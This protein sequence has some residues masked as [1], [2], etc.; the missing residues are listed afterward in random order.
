MNCPPGQTYSSLLKRCVLKE[1]VGAKG[2][3]AVPCPEGQIWNPAPASRRCVSRKVFGDLY[4]EGRLKAASAEQRRL[5]GTQ[6]ASSVK[7]PAKPAKVVSPVVPRAAA[8][9]PANKRNAAFNVG[10]PR[11]NSTMPPGLLREK[12]LEWV[13]KNCTNQEDPIMLEPYEEAELKDLRSMV[14]LNSGFCY[15]AETIDQHIKS[16]IERGVPIRD[17]LN[18]SY[19]LDSKDFGAIDTAG[20]RAKKSYKLPVEPVEIPANHYKLLIDVMDDPKFKYVFLYDDRKVKKLPGGGADYS[21]AIPDGA[22][23]GYIP[24]A[25]T[26]ELVTLIRKAYTKGRLFTRAT[27]PFL[28]C[29]FHLKKSKEFWA[30]ETDKKIKSMTEEIRDII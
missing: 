23:I 7:G 26:D 17:I 29:R 10:A 16:S 15:T 2:R 11:A 4:G 8:I 24:A 12:M 14:K 21:D 9:T 5:R 22:W 18:P 13:R 20:K 6:K 19:R 27:R 25:G 30:T 28:C 1:I 3:S